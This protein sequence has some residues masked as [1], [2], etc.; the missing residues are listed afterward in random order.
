MKLGSGSY[1]GPFSFASRF[2]NDR[3]TNPEE[4]IGAAHAG[5]F[6]MFLAGLLTGAGFVPERIATT[7]KV[8]LGAGPTIT[9][10]ELN[11]QAEVPN[12]TEA[13]LQKHADEAKK[14]CPVSKALAG[15]EVRLH[16]QLV[17]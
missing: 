5:C 7:A 15:P 2:E 13:D 14:N 3:G 17:R 11:T 10:I 4:L 12:L 9:L 6:S 16:V 1:E 8:H